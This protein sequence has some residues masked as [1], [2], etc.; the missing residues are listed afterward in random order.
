MN[1]HTHAVGVLFLF[2]SVIAAQGKALSAEDE[3]AKAKQLI[4]TG[5]FEESVAHW[6]DAAT[7]FDQAG[8]WNGKCE[9]EIQLAAAYNALGQTNLAIE[10][11]RVVEAAAAEKA[12]VK[13]V[14]AAKVALGAIYILSSP[15]MQMNMDH[16]AMSE[17]DAEANL[18]EGLKL[19]RSV[20]DSHLEAVALNNLANLHNYQKQFDVA[21]QEYRSAK[22]VAETSRDKDLS[23]QVCANLAYACTKAGDYEEAEASADQAISTASKSPD[24]HSKVYNLLGAGRTL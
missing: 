11:L 4:A 8:D 13:H 5:A 3:F 20:R 12:D 10:R 2:Y 16:G 23:S 15:R 21:K 1:R 6:K 9:A 7:Q 22:S 18:K 17:G 19:A 14:A 24:S